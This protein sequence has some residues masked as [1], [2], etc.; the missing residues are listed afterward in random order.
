M[1]RKA[2]RTLRKVRNRTPTP[3]P[4]I[5]ATQSYMNVS[6]TWKN[7]QGRRNIVQIRNGKGIKQVEVLGSQG[8]VTKSKTRRL[9]PQESQQ[10]LRGKFIPGLWRNC[11][12]G[13]N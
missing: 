9:T 5:F 1:V 11:C 12:V 4:R 2:K 13:K 10:I 7:G 6:Q 8:E 3:H